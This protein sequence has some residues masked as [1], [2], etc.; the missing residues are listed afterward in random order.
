MSGGIEENLIIELCIPH[1]LKLNISITS[2]DYVI[3]IFYLS[4]LKPHLK[5]VIVKLA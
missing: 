4:D 2:G 5:T 3:L 1:L